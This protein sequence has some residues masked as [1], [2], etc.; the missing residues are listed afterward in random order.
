[1]RKTNKNLQ[2]DEIVLSKLQRQGHWSSTHTLKL[3]KGQP[4]EFEGIYFFWFDKFVKF[5]QG[6]FRWGTDR[7][8]LVGKFE[9]NIPFVAYL[10]TR[11]PATHISF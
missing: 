9:A 2:K 5:I 7:L 8:W 4:I 3:E 1:M 11:V 10:N 6:K